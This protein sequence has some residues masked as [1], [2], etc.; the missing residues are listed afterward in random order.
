[1]WSKKLQAI[2]SL[3]IS[4]VLHKNNEKDQQLIANG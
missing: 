3:A 4:G 2:R 1:M